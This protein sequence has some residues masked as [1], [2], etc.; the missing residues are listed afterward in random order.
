[1]PRRCCRS[2]C[3]RR[4]GGGRTCQEATCGESRCLVDHPGV[5]V[6]HV[7]VEVPSA[8]TNEVVGDAQVDGLGRIQRADFDI[9]LMDRSHEPV[10][11]FSE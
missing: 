1:L 4:C 7:R 2:R 5:R 10:V 8:R 9:R 3:L 11:W 6:L